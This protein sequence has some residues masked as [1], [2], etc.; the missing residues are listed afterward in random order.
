MDP[1]IDAILLS[2]LPC[3]AALLKHFCFSP[4][5]RLYKFSPICGKW[6][7]LQLCLAQIK[8]I[9]YRFT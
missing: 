3:C 2:G 7:S 5:E 8:E 6:K 1:L 9:K 4:A